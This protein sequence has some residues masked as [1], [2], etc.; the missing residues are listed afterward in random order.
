MKK[1]Q[2]HNQC[3]TPNCQCKMQ[4]PVQ[5]QQQVKKDIKAGMK[6]SY[7]T[8]NS[9]NATVV[10]S[11]NQ[12]N[13]IQTSDFYMKHLQPRNHPAHPHAYFDNSNSVSEAKRSRM[14]LAEQQHKL[15][16]QQLFQH[17]MQLSLGHHYQH[18]QSYYRPDLRISS[19]QQITPPESLAFWQQQQQQQQQQQMQAAAASMCRTAGCTGHPA[20]VVA[21]YT[22]Y[23]PPVH[24]PLCY[25]MPPTPMMTVGGRAAPPPFCLGCAQCARTGKCQ[26]VNKENTLGIMRSLWINFS[27]IQLYFIVNILFSPFSFL[28]HPL[29]L[30]TFSH[31]LSHPLVWLNCMIPSQISDDE[32]TG[33]ISS[34]F[35]SLEIL[36]KYQNSNIWHCLRHLSQEFFLSLPPKSNFFFLKNAFFSVN[37]HP[38]PEEKKYKCNTS[39]RY[40]KK[41]NIGWCAMC[42]DFFHLFNKR[43]S[44]NKNTTPSW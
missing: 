11:S 27:S 26:Q 17:Q 4:P 16:Q 12:A 35:S 5:Q 8:M 41:K 1:E 20:A 38:G 25:P 36:S 3:S 13:Q 19:F 6:R 21:G 22:K 18:Q 7:N 33:S 10:T 44:K 23:S 34:L 30:N 32:Y 9:N 14:H 29:K 31:F 28:F 42:S 15:R 43:S 37:F 24:P 39:M 2:L 40:Q